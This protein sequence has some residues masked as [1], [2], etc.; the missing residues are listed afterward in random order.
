LI[1]I[2]KDDKKSPDLFSSF[3]IELSDGC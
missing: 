1:E 3:G 2:K